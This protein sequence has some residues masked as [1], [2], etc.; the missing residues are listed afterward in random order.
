MNKE[1][2]AP[3]CTA[4]AKL[5][6]CVKWDMKGSHL[7]WCALKVEERPLRHECAWPAP[8]ALAGT[9]L[10][11]FHFAHGCIPFGK[12]NVTLFTDL[13]NC[14]LPVHAV[15]KSQYTHY[16]K[17]LCT[18]YAS[19]RPHQHPSLP[20]ALGAVQQ[21]MICNSTVALELLKM[22]RSWDLQETALNMMLAL[23]AGLASPQ[24]SQILSCCD[25]FEGLACK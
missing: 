24:S 21:R 19:R 23:A 10:G 4:C 5:S 7:M 25:R 12:D 2:I 11:A 16:V 1:F 20:D 15:V 17:S 18:C 8:D 3:A 22:L 13:S 14:G 9:E 6:F